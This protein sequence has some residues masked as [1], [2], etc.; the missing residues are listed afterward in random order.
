MEKEIEG[1]VI[2]YSKY[3]DVFTDQEVNILEKIEE[4]GVVTIVRINGKTAGA[5]DI[6]PTFSA[7]YNK[8]LGIPN[9]NKFE[10]EKA[11]GFFLDKYSNTVIK[12]SKT[13]HLDLEVDRAHWD[14]CKFNPTLKFTKDAAL[15]D[16]DALWYVEIPELESKNNIDKKRILNKAESL[17][18][19][20]TKEELIYRARLLGLNMEKDKVET[21]QE[22]LLMKAETL[23]GAKKI[24]ELYDGNLMSVKLLFL[25]A[26]DLNIITHDKKSGLYTY[27]HQPMGVSED[28]A[29]M[30]LKDKRHKSI[31]E[32]LEND[33]EVLSGKKVKL[34]SKKVD[35]VKEDDSSDEFVLLDN[36]EL[37]T[38]DVLKNINLVTLRKEAIKMGAEESDVESLMTKK[39]ILAEM[40]KYK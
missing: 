37:Y 25:K 8:F 21:I 40:Y 11:E 10:Q 15:V 18:L 33:I 13:F 5:T 36:I 32:N 6:R 14:M 20:D 28:A 26:L 16:G 1:K 31:L 29:L 7:Q 3:Y 9:Y 22:I 39:E 24:I 30:Y 27:G 34:S 12:E 19:N 38:K 17:I 23:S 35:E 4:N 2:D